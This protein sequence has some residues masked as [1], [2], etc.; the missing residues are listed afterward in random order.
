MATTTTNFSFIEPAVLSNTDANVWGGMLNT[1]S[2]NLDTYLTQITGSYIGNSAPV[3]GT[4]VTP[5]SGQFWINNTVSSS[6]PVQIYD[7]ASWV[8]IGTINTVNHTFTAPA[9]ASSINVQVFSSS[10]T[11]TPSA[12]LSYA[13]VEVQAGGGGAGF[14]NA[15]SAYG[16]SGGGGGYSKSALS[17][18]TIGAS[19]T[20]TIGTGGSGGASMNTNGAAGGS[21]SFGSL[22]SATGGS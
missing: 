5:T 2:S 21:S 12:N 19:Q 13:V 16:A 22:L 17:A 11:Y 3:L 15:N 18:T 14:T 10:G 8:L 7:G 6:W 4:T 1:N 9:T 20:I